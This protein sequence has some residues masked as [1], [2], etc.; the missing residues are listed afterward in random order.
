MYALFWAQVL[1]YW[2]QWAEHG[3]TFF[4]NFEHEKTWSQEIVEDEDNFAKVQAQI[5]VFP[6]S[7][8]NKKS[9]FVFSSLSTGDLSQIK[10]AAYWAG[11]GL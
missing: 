9:N 5:H 7:K 1:S 8:F 11:S 6:S 3:S 4:S 10:G 2:A